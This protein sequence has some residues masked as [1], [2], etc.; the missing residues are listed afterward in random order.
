MKTLIQSL[1][2]IFFFASALLG[3]DASINSLLSEGKYTIEHGYN[4]F[5]KAQLLKAHSIFERLLSAQPDNMSALYY[6]TY[7]EYRIISYGLNK[8]D[9]S[10][11]E[12]FVDKAVDNAK[13]LIE[14]SQYKSEGSTLLAALY[15]MKIVNNQ[16]EAVVLT[17]RLHGLL[18]DAQEVDS[19]NPRS[20]LIRGIMKFNTPEF[21]GGSKEDAINNFKHAISLYKKTSNNDSLKINWGYTEAYTWL[22]IALRDTK[23]ITEA[24]DSFNKALEIAPDNGWVKYTLL[25]ELDKAEAS[26]K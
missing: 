19:S 16:I 9:K 13:K 12:N 23:R 18:D 15:M 11:Y 21:F 1:L 17:P 2:L 22:G 14:S 8:P 4:Q 26:T 6:L 3:Q 7:S 25:P 20:Y 24:K 10:L 5:D